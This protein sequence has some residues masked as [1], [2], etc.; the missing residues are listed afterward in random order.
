MS[1]TTTNTCT[2]RWLA[3]HAAGLITYAE[4]DQRFAQEFAV[5]I[6]A[7]APEPCRGT[8]SAPA[9]PAHV[10]LDTDHAM[11]I[12]RWLLGRI[13]HGHFLQT[14]HRLA[15]WAAD[16][17]YRDFIV[18]GLGGT[19]VP[20]LTV[21]DPSVKKKKRAQLQLVFDRAWYVAQT[22]EESMKIAARLSH[23]TIA[24]ELARVGGDAYALHP[25]TAEWFLSDPT[26][27]S[28]QADSVELPELERSASAEHIELER[29][30]EREQLVAL[31]I[32]PSVRDAFVEERSVDG[33]E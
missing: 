14:T 13:Q 32:A 15:T 4:A 24:R 20:G 7:L 3:A 28:Y 31:A 26:I 2:D 8:A 29:H 11:T 9:A 19:M 27:K 10:P 17:R 25:D 1:P 23:R 5:A 33:I 6:L 12:A 22:T 18:M 30:V 16:V 21:G